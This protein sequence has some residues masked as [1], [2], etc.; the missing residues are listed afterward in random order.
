MLCTAN[1]ETPPQENVS[2]PKK[3]SRWTYTPFMIVSNWKYFDEISYAPKFEPLVDKVELL[4]SNL[5]YAHVHLQN[6]Y[7]T[8]YTKR[9]CI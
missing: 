7:K 5:N 1:N 9:Q 8:S 6:G 3:D 4:Q 2:S